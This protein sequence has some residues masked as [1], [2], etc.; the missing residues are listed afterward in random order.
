MLWVQDD[1]GRARAGYKGRAGDCVCRAICIAAELDYQQTYDALNIARANPGK[2]SEK[3][4]RDL[5]ANTSARNGINKRTYDKFIREELGWEW[6]PTMFIGQGCKVHLR[7]EE[8]PLGRLICRCSKHLVAVI[9]GVIHDTHDPSR[10]GD[11]CV[12]GY[13]RKPEND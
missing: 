4:R 13:Y 2:V 5:L 12:Y 7:A 3:T 1:G 8:L 6:V 10:D 9:D 11:R